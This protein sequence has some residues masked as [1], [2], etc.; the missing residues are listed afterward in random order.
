MKRALLAT[1]WI[2]ALAAGTA[3]ALELSG[4]LARPD[5]LLGRA[6]NLWPNEPVVFGHYLVVIALGFAAAWTMWLMTDPLRRV[7]VLCL[8]IAELIGAAWLLRLVGIFFPPL[9]AIVAAAVA[10][11]LAFLL[12][13]TRSARQQRAAA[14]LF[15]GRLAPAARERLTKSEAFDLSQPIAREASFLFCGIAN[16]ADLID[17]LSP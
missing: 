2:G 4:L 1:L 3:I 14:R 5:A 7:A 8:V 17:E 11:L 6:L 12:S 13:A 10:T 16:E 15:R 9:P